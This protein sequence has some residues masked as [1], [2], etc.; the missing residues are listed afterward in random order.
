VVK[1]ITLHAQLSA[2]SQ[3]SV[4]DGKSGLVMVGQQTRCD[5]TKTDLIRLRTV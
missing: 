4:S 1:F 2:S 3:Q 5:A